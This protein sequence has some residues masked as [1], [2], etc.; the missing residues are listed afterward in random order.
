MQ[1]TRLLRLAHTSV[2]DECSFLACCSMHGR[3]LELPGVVAGINPATPDRSLFNGV[4]YE[5]PEALREHYDAISAAYEDAGVRAWTV[6]VRIGDA[7]TPAFLKSRGHLFDYDP[8]AM[9]TRIHELRLPAPGDLDWDET[10]DL[11]LIGALNDTAFGFPPPAFEAAFDRWPNRRW[12]GYVARVDGHAVS[13]LLSCDTDDGDCSITA[14]ATLP[15]YQGRGLATRLMAAAL[16]RAQGR[17]M[18]STSLQASPSGATV[19]ARLGYRELG[20]MP[21]WERRGAPPGMGSALGRRAG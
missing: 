3:V 8:V 10:E 16:R 4:A 2:V 13:A 7:D 20:R 5:S 11:R 12:R 19:Y 18:T 1:D 15:E 9:G 6:W 14:V 17:G 21:M